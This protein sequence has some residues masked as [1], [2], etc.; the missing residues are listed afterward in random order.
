MNTTVG[1]CSLRG[2]RVSVPSMWHSILDPWNDIYEGIAFNYEDDKLITAIELA[3]A[4][5]REQ[6]Q[7]EIA[8]RDETIRQLQAQIATLTQERDDFHMRYRIQ[9]DVESKAA[10]VRAEAAEARCATLTAALEPFAALAE[11]YDPPE[12]DDHEIVWDRK[13][14]LGQ[15]R[16]ARAALAAAPQ[17]RETPDPQKG[18]LTDVEM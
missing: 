17:G 13:P 5:E 8:Q 7:R 9:C 10:L 2:G 14:T 18:E 16:A 11:C 6:H 4:A 1:T 15:L 12:D 3:R